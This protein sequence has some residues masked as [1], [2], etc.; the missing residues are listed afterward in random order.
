MDL[1]TLPVEAQAPAA[2]PPSGPVLRIQKR[3]DDRRLVTPLVGDKLT[4]GS[5]PRCQVRLPAADVRPLQ[6]LIALESQAATATRWAAGVLLNGREFTKAPLTNGDRLSI[7]PWVIELEGLASTVGTAALVSEAVGEAPTPA[8]S[9][10]TEPTG[11]TLPYEPAAPA[12]IRVDATASQTFAD[13]VVLELWIANDQARRRSKRL[14][15]AIRADRFQVD[16]L[17][18]DLSAMETELD[19]ARAAYDSRNETDDRLQA[20]V[21]KERQ[22]AEE[23]VAPLVQDIAELRNLLEA[24]QAALADSAAECQRLSA[25]L[26]S[27]NGSYEQFAASLQTETTRAADLESA[28]GDRQRQLEEL[29]QALESTRAELAASVAAVA[30]RTLEWNELQAELAACR[31]ER[32]QLA[33]LRHGE[34][35]RREPA[36]EPEETA[37]LPSTPQEELV[38]ERAPDSAAWP[39]DYAE[40]WPAPETAADLVEPSPEAAPI[41]WDVQPAEFGPTSAAAEPQSLGDVEA[42]TG[43]AGAW[44]EASDALAWASGPENASPAI[45]DFAAAAEA[46]STAVAA[47]P[48]EEMA[49]VVAPEPPPAEFTPPSFIDKYKHLLDEEEA[50]LPRPLGRPAGRLLDEEYLS[51]AKAE[52]AAHVDEDSDA[53][54]EAYMSNMMRRVRGGEAPVSRTFMPTA[55]QSPTG[56]AAPAVEPTCPL[57]ATPAVDLSAAEETIG[58]LDVE[59]LRGA[60]RKPPLSADL[61]AM[62]EIANASARTAIASSHQRRDHDSAVGRI[63]AAVAFT[64]ASAYLLAS[65]PQIDSW[66]FWAGVSTATAGVYAAVQVLRIE[67]R[68]AAIRKGG[69]FAALMNAEPPRAEVAANDS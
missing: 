29:G 38:V 4:I 3:G 44:A 20:D 50:P 57:A 32:D 53:A 18:A 65:A 62:R 41:A 39:A 31:A 46:D 21:A 45:D 24:A 68:R 25:R 30:A 11:I 56:Y 12:V 9:R 43:E 58:P 47:A 60:T 63:G 35:D 55:P 69:I 28:L 37:E 15:A 22:L 16:A 61:A 59:A 13:R 52:V 10:V 48:D 51:P 1:L 27:A 23:R 66:W 8:P 7:G 2:N 34:A 14:I 64:V 36:R 5:S 54:L 19:L 67:R 6:C 49:S 42:N 40:P 17:V 33:E 26:S